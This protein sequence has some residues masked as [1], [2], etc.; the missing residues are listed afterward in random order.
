MWDVTSPQRVS[1]TAERVRRPADLLSALLSLAAVV[2]VIGSIHALP[3]GSTELS[4]Y[5]SDFLQNIPSWLSSVAAV[6]AGIS[7]F[8]LVVTILFIQV[9]HQ[10]RDARNA[11]AASVVAGA[12]MI[13]AWSIWNA[14]NGVVAHAVLHGK[15]PTMLVVDTGYV[16]FVVGCDLVRRS[17]WSRWCTGTVIALLLTGLAINTLTPYAVAIVGFGGLLAGWLVRWVLGAASVRPA[18]G[19]LI[20]WL[21]RHGVM[22]SAL[23]ADG[24]PDQGHLHGIRA[25]GTQVDVHLADRDTYGSGLAR[26]LWSL[27][28]LRPVVTGRIPLGSRAQLYQMALASSLA[29]KADVPSPAVLLLEEM[30]NET[31]VLV[32]AGPPGDHPGDEI[33]PESAAALFASLRTL[34]DAGIAHR[35]LRPD[36]LVITRDSAGFS[37]FA[38]A[39]PGASALSRRLDLAQLLVTVTRLTDADTAIAALRVGYRPADEAAVAAVM[40]PVALAPWGWSAM[41]GGQAAL[42]KIR[43]GLLGP[44]TA[45]PVTRLERFRWRTVISAFA[46]TIAAY[47]LIGQLRQVN[48]LGTLAHT[49]LGWFAVALVGSAVTYFAAAQNLAAF[50]PKRLSAVRGSLVQ[51]S[52]AFLGVAMPPTVGHVAVNA[53]Y[54]HRQSV[55]ENAIAAA[56]TLSQLVNVAATVLLLVALGLLT[57][58]G[59]SRFHIVLGTNVLIGLAVIAFA[60]GVAVAIPQT[61]A[62]L[63]SLVWPHLRDLWPRLLD[64]M[65]DP[66]RLALGAGANLLLTASYLL[67]F[68]ASLYAVGAR[69]AILPAAVIYLAG[70][71][72]GSAAPTPGGVGGV[73][74]V[75]TLGLVGMGIPSAE[76]LSGILVFRVATFYLP[77]PAGWLAYLGLQR[78]GTL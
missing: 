71:F 50:V 24:S 20:A 16:A 65:S 53:R 73:E 40:Q 15:N 64:A 8:L 55:D 59:L 4:G 38:A 57:G 39:V 17:R 74:G 63:S 13:T 78:S 3:L 42:T 1:Q 75:L 19:D 76:A 30:P 43:H 45:V 10:W 27:A 54:L 46:L 34:H 12:A 37:S 7:C 70:N 9:R 22:V 44:G 33:G 14:E 23:A 31:L 60:A 58:S 29:R 67:A 32:T 25:D 62:K 61:R 56:V 47:L 72:V 51:L 35:D 11:I 77:I 66:I 41:R 69:P 21:E 26:R 68:F 2:I 28:R 36:N 48:L 49:N 6:A 5:V 18:L 52:T